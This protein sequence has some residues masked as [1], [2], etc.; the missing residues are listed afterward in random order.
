MSTAEQSLENIKKEIAS[1]ING[2]S[3]PSQSLTDLKQ[4]DQ[5][6]EKIISDYHNNSTQSKSAGEQAEVLY[7]FQPQQSGDLALKSGD[8]ITIVERLSQDWFKGRDSNNNEG[9]FPANYVKVVEN[10]RPAGRPLAPPPPSYSSTSVA[11]TNTGGSRNEYYNQ[12]VP[13]QQQTAQQQA[14]P[15]PPASTNYY[16][17]PVQ[18][19]PVQQQPVQQQQTAQQ[20]PSAF[21]NIGSKLGNAFVFGAGATLGGDLVNAI[22]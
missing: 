22:L 8:K 13:Q 18:Q 12:S 5:L 14:P 19:Q 16:Q 2:N 7:D 4:V 10:S 3:L 9:V 17:Q 11:A 15:F 1:L 6:V 20:K 21:G